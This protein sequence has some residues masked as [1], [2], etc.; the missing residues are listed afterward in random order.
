MDWLKTKWNKLNKNAK[1]F[2]CCAVVLI[3]AGIL[4]N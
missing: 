1:I 4:F 3:I 2:I